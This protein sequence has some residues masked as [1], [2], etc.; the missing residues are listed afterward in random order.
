M[1]KLIVTR[2]DESI[3]GN[4]DDYNFIFNK[5][6]GFFARWGETV[7]HDPCVAPSPEL[8]D[9][10]IS[11][12]VPANTTPSEDMLLT[13]GGCNGRGCREFC[14]KDNGKGQLMGHMSLSLFH[15]IAAR[16][17]E[18]VCQI[19]FGICGAHSHPEMLKIF[20]AC[21]EDYD[22]VPNVTVNGQGIDDDMAERLAQVCGAVAV[23]VNPHNTLESYPAIQRLGKHLDQVNVHFVMHADSYE[24]AHELL[25]DVERYGLPVRAVV[26][27]AY[28]HKNR[29]CT[30]RGVRDVAKYQSIIAHAERLGIGIGFDSCSSDMYMACIEDHPHRERLA[31]YVE[32]CESSLFSAYI[33]FKGE[34]YPCSFT[35]GENGWEEG[36]RVT[37]Y[38]SFDDVWNHPLTEGFRRELLWKC[39]S[40]PLFEVG[41]ESRNKSDPL[42]E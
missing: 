14:Y 34:F 17:P 29:S 33:N 3:C 42:N 28:K 9:I 2:D 5:Q 8:C 37:D 1:S 32:P 11:S 20:R 31:Q 13:K 10:E 36:I 23:S 22:I 12:I 35:E 39:R 4:S 26:F 25:D 6:N 16:L 38:R 18:T 21:R 27:L 7:D 30:C 19:A 41:P 40:C 15:K 24:F